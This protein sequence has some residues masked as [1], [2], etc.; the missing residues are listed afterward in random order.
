M[1]IS[2][3]SPHVDPNFSVIPSIVAGI[4]PFLTILNFLFFI[5]YIFI[6]WKWLIITAVV[7]FL[8]WTPMTKYWAFNMDRVTH[9]AKQVKVGTLNLYGLKKV[10]TSEDAGLKIQL[11]MVLEKAAPDVICF[12]ESN[13]YSNKVLDEIL[14][15]DYKYQYL[16][17]GVKIVS[18]YAIEDRGTFD[19]NS[20]VNSCL[21]ADLKAGDRKIRVYCAH[22]QS[23][24]V[25]QNADELMEKGN[26]TER[27][28]WADIGNIMSS[29][30]A[31]AVARVEQ[32]NR[33]KTHANLSE[34]PVIFCG[35]LNDHVLSYSI[36]QLSD[37]WQD[38][39]IEAGFGGGTTYA[40]SVPMLRIDYIMV[41]SN[42]IVVDHEIS[43][44]QSSDH[45]FVSAR[46]D[47]KE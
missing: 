24:R 46:L 17:S 6:D 23:N 25:S 27:K 21:W 4:F 26:L 22:L 32:T 14:D 36:H 7:S 3:L 18:K 19:F 31:S 29:Y 34:Y 20:K 38:T 47:I 37:G 33:I 42:F 35:D 43:N 9:H 5:T 39:F 45:Y 15:F 8:F 40:G 2:V 28:T 1:V 10:K 44:T 30:K 13:G 16:E 12:Q 41:D 11:K